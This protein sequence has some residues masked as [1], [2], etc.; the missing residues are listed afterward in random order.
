MKVLIAGATGVL[1]RRL[2]QPLRNRTMT[3]IALVRSAKGE[4]IVQSP[5]ADT[6]LAEIGLHLKQ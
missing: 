4:Q 2:V 6:R 5:G 1:G 3:A